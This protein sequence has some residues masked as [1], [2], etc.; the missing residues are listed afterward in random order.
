MR[1][2]TLCRSR[3]GPAP[4]W[5]DDVRWALNARPRSAD[6]ARLRDERRERRRVLAELAL[7]L[8]RNPFLESSPERAP[9]CARRAQSRGA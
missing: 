9:S 8:R 4:A 5:H 3:R 2:T 7:L 6:A 1:V